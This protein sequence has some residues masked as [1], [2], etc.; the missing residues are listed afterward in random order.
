MMIAAERHGEFVAHLATEG[1]GL[2]E[3]QMMGVGRGLSADQAG[4]GAD[5]REMCLVP[6]PRRFLGE[7][8]T[9]SPINS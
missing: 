6:L 7:C 4:L 2:G 1:S 9:I 8:E 3:F 5:E